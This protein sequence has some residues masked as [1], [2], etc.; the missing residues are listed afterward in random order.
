MTVDDRAVCLLETDAWEERPGPGLEAADERE[1]DDLAGEYD[2][3]VANE[4][5]TAE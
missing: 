3:V 1:I 4:R 2:H 5:E